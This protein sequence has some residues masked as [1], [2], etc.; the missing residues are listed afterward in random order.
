MNKKE[1]MNFNLNN[2]LLAMSTPL[3]FVEKNVCNTSNNHSKRVAYIA[4]KFAQKLN[5]DQKEISDLCSYS[6]IHNNGLYNAQAKNKN[7]FNESEENIKFFPF[8]SN[9]TNILKYQNEHFDGSGPFGLKDKEIPL[10]SQIIAFAD[11]LESKFDLSNENV[12]NRIE[13]ESFVRSNINC[14]FSEELVKYYLDFSSSVDFWLDLQNENDILIYIY[15]NLSDF[16]SVLTFE[17]ILEI[18]SVFMYIMDKDS[19]LLDKC[20]KMSEYYNFEHKDKLTLFIAASLQNIGKFL[21]PKNIINKTTKLNNT[22]YELVKSYPYYT[23]KALSNIMGF[24]NI[25]IWASNIQETLDGKG[26][27]YKLSAKDLSLKDRLM[28]SLNIY[29][30]LRKDKS[31]RKAF[32][33]EE[34]IVLMH[35]MAEEG[36]LDKAIIN[37]INKVLS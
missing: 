21:I 28:A 10:F 6:L 12:Q 35:K 8:L 26:Y 20:I 32:S 7:Y 30:S 22:E 29:E 34:S 31:Y 2:F 5:F 13:V 18:T 36:K 1:E 37:D 19:A 24:N 27:P 25:S 11:I 23:K 33:K 15:S 16:T 17:E 9:K 3:D 4:L 14:L